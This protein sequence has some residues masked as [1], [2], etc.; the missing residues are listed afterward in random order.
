MQNVLYKKSK[1]ASQ[2][3]PKGRVIHVGKVFYGE[4][5]GKTEDSTWELNK[6]RS[7]NLRRVFES[8][9]HVTKYEHN[10]DHDYVR[11]TFANS[12]DAQQALTALSD[13]KKCYEI[14]K[15]LRN[16]IFEHDEPECTLPLLRKYRYEYANE[17]SKKEKKEVSKQEVKPTEAT[18][19]K[20]EKVLLVVP[21]APKE[22]VWTTPVTPIAGAQSPNKKATPRKSAPKTKVAKEPIVDHKDLQQQ[23]EKVK[24]ALD[25]AYLSNQYRSIVKNLKDHE[26][27]LQAREQ[28]IMKLDNELKQIRI[29]ESRMAEQLRNELSWRQSSLE[30]MYTLREE[31]KHFE[32]QR[33]AVNNV[34]PIGVN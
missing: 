18:T 13:E 7:D 3:S 6:M 30:T 34:T 32:T 20:Q 12:R 9:G 21:S 17:R 29:N 10:W 22:T 33:N 1:D 15:K 2:E 8:F 19:K 14:I 27:R 25:V 16:D 26:E 31:L 28:R 5:L 24:Q 11:V 23:V 4:H